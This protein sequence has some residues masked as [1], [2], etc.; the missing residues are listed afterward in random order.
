M[1]NLDKRIK[2]TWKSYKWVSKDAIYKF[3]K[4]ADYRDNKTKVRSLPTVLR[5]QKL[6]NTFLDA[7]WKF[8]NDLK[9]ESFLNPHNDFV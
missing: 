3:T 6:H 4:D 5:Q 1:N 8:S 2:D 9:P 7:Q